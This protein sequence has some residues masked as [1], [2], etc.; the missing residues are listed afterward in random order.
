MLRFALF[1]KGYDPAST[2]SPSLRQ[3]TPQAPQV[4]GSSTAD[5][6]N[7]TVRS[8][9]PSGSQEPEDSAGMFL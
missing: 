2:H 3:E 1:S 9:D 8:R 5:S 4:N 7:T 6:L